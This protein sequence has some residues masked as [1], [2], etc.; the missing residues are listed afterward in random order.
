MAYSNLA[1]LGMLAGDTAEA[2][3][4]GG[5]AIEL[6]ERLG[7]TEIL[8]H[9]LNNVGTAEL[10]AG[11]PAGRPA[12]ERSLALARGRRPGGARRP[13]LHQPRLAVA[14]E[15]RDY[16]LAAR[17]LRRGDR[18]LHR[19]RPRHLAA[20]HAGRRRPG[21]TSSRDAGPRPPAPPRSCSAT[22]GPRRSAGSSPWPS[23]AG[24]AP[25]GATPGCGRPWT[26]RW[27]WR[28][29]RGAAT[30]RP[31]GGRPGRGGLAGRAT[32][33]RP[34]RSWPSAATLAVRVEGDGLAGRRA[35]LLAAAPG[36][37]RPVP[38]GGLPATGRTAAAV[39]AADGRRHGDAAAAA[40]GRS[41][42]R[43]RPPAPWPTATRRRSSARR[44]PSSS[45]WAPARW[46]RR[47]PAAAGAGRPGPGPRAP[48]GDPG[49][50]GPPDGPRARGPGPGRRGPAQRRD[51]RAPVH[52][53]QDGRP[54]R[55][56]HP[57]QARRAAPGGEAARAA[58]RLG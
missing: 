41:A 2:V 14:L 48:P 44:W 18:L 6:A 1:Q 31:G 19:A 23:S 12:L 33:P 8:V 52:L 28:R 24:S 3:A 45:G 36:R 21:P 11:R 35:R 9:A 50:P 38:A 10:Q 49:Q 13:R 55:L 15:Q 43:T 42:A 57:G 34:G 54:P 51:R 29:D 25:A 22:R 4:W 20:V 53:P 27:P 17:C 46:P 32:R 39:R 5:R 30:A 56:G 26:R 37:A 47:S 16:R 40:G 58:A 7:Q